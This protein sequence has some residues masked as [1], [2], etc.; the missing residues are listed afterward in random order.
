M[1]EV[2]LDKLCELYL[3]QT[4][5]THSPT[6]VLLTHPVVDVS[7]NRY[8]SLPGN[9]SVNTYTTYQLLLS[10][11]TQHFIGSTHMP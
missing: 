6:T 3:I 8:S 11:H 10:R 5:H 9:T 7:T 1:C 4:G 2:R